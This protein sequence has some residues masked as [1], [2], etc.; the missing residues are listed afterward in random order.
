MPVSKGAQ[1]RM[2]IA[3]LASLGVGETLLARART[4]WLHISLFSGRPDLSESIH[5][6]P[7]ETPRVQSLQSLSLSVTE[8]AEA[9]AGAPRLGFHGIRFGSLAHSLASSGSAL[10]LCT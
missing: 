4:P 9:D 7:A 10:G 8:T 2:V 6:P 5:G 3:H 1:D